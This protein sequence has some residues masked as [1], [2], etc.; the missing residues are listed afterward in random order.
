MA[1]HVINNPKTFNGELRRFETTDRGL[2]SVFNDVIQVL[3]NNEVY[4]KDVA[5]TTSSD[6]SSHTDNNNIHVSNTEKQTWNAKASTSVATTEKDGLMSKEDKNTINNLEK[7]ITDSASAG[8]IID[9]LLTVDGSGSGLDA[10]LL[11]GR[12]S[13]DFASA[14][15]NHE[16]TYLKLSG[17]EIT[18]NLTATGTI[19]A[20]RVLNAFYNDLAEA[21]DFEGNLTAGDIVEITNKNSVQKASA[22]SKKVIGVISDCYAMLFGGNE[23]DIKANRK[24]A[25]G[26]IGQISVKIK[27]KAEI[28]DLIVSCGDGIGVVSENPKLGTVIAKVLE[29]KEDEKIKRILCLVYPS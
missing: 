20:A 22:N 4:L 19:S 21:F 14:L 23:E 13:T 1:N 25:V 8:S 5:N 18:G 28:G 7:T 16:G 10:D 12:D 17:G 26:L 11:D 29:N 27:G 3:I 2:A 24:I 15:H 9:K 6:F